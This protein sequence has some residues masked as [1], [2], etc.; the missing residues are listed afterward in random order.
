[1]LCL[2]GLIIKQLIAV[3]FEMLVFTLRFVAITVEA[4]WSTSPL[5]TALPLIFTCQK[6]VTILSD[7]SMWKHS[8]VLDPYPRLF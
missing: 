3:V 6:V 8:Q 1:L 4:L 7:K 2:T 5:G